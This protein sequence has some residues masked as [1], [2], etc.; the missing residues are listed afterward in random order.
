MKTNGSYWYEAGLAANNDYT[1][2]AGAN[3]TWRE[4]VFKCEDD[5][6]GNMAFHMYKDGGATSVWLP[7]DMNLSELQMRFSTNE[8]A[9]LYMTELRGTVKEGATAPIRVVADSFNT[10]TGTEVTAEKPNMFATKSTE[11][12]TSHSYTQDGLTNVDLN[13]YDEILFYARKAGSDDK[14]GWFESVQ[15]GSFVIGYNWTEFKLVK[16][17]DGT[18]NIW[19]GG[20]LKASNQTLTNLSD[21][22]ATYGINHYYF[23]EVFGVGAENVEVPEEPEDEGPIL[24]GEYMVVTSPWA[25]HKGTIDNS[26]TYTEGGYEYATLV[27]GGHVYYEKVRMKDVDLSIFSEFRFAMKTNGSYWYEAGLATNNDYTMIAGANTTWREFVFKCEDDGTGTEK[28]HM[29]KDGSAT[30]TW[31]PA[32]MNLSELQMRF[33]T[34]ESAVLYMTELRG[35]VKEGTRLPMKVVADSFNTKTGTEVTSEK[36]NFAA[37]KS[38][39]A[40]TSHSYT[41]DA[42][43][44]VDLSSYNKILFYAR[45]AGSDDKTGWFESVQLGS[46]VMG[47]NWTEFKLVKNAD[48]TWNVWTGGVLKASNLTLTNLSDLTATYGINHYYFSE[49][50]GVLAD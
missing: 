45:K 41:Q 39:E 33:S 1:M 11:V 50:F 46:F 2:I 26:Q 44:S 10:K 34:N 12:V 5:G 18:W 21:V 3:T 31:L 40:V 7:S 6:T 13:L 38:T 36:P 37:T 17:E 20:V 14:T 42:L 8:S 23:S 35:T 49:V 32:D 28:F 19:T 27:P 29:Y 48:G 47:Y 15:L 25:Y 4:F 16:N 43:T 24:S 22:T 30:G 9:V